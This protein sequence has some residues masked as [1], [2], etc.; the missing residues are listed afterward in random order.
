[1]DHVIATLL[2][3]LAALIVFGVIALGIKWLIATYMPPGKLRDA[4]LRERFS[5]G[6]SEANRRVLEQ[7]V[8]SDRRRSES[9]HIE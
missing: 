1:M 4:I 3:P 8:R 5:S 9:V 6:Y 2:A 7:A